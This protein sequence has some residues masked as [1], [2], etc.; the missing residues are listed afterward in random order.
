[1]TVELRPLGVTC[2]IQCQY[3]YQNPQRD[4]RDG[5]PE[6][7]LA[8][9]KEAVLAEGGPFSLF[10]GEPLL[11]PERDLEDLWSWGLEKF[12]RNSLQTNGVLI[13]DWHVDA[14]KKYRV[15]V[16]VSLDGPGELNDARWAG[17]L[18]KTRRATA[19]AELAV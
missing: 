1:M 2:N 4:A 14:F 11:V 12:G 19:A 5:A 7:D 16:G 6:Y 8:R 10:G 18:E 17:T 13:S 15:Q 3:C 9:M